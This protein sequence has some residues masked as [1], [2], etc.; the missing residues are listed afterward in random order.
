MAKV[1]ITI[2]DE[3]VDGKPGLSHIFHAEPEIEEN[4]HFDDWT[5]AQKL[6]YSI[7]NHITATMGAPAYIGKEKFDETVR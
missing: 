1:V 2:E 5:F 7:A 3:M 4:S 6:A